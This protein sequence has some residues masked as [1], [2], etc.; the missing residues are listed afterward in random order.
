M[1][2]ESFTCFVKNNYSGKLHEETNY[3]DG[4]LDGITKRYYESGIIM[5]E[6]NYKD[7][8]Y[9][10]IHKQ[11]YK[12][13]KLKQEEKWTNDK[14]LSMVCYNEQ[15][16]VIPPPVWWQKKLQGE[17]NSGCELIV[18]IKGDHAEGDF[19]IL[20]KEDFARR[21]VERKILIIELKQY[22]TA[23]SSQ[24]E[25]RERGDRIC[26]TK[27][28]ENIDDMRSKSDLYHWYKDERRL[29]RLSEY[30]CGKELFLSFDFTYCE[31]ENAA[32]KLAYKDELKLRENT[33]SVKKRVIKELPEEMFSMDF[34][35]HPRPPH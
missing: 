25:H 16:K 6:E 17:L 31:L 22:G 2:K 18:H 13:V 27:Y 11:Y 12:S 20:T 19:E 24:D 33:F 26:Y 14:Q 8:M 5:E 35:F 32:E 28:K 3:K 23:A 34:G 7:N 9:E 21:V 29:R 30:N 4:K 10:G 15:G 1:T